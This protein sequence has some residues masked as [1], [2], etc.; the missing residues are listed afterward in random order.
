MRFKLVLFAAVLSGWLSACK[1][2][3]ISSFNKDASFINFKQ[4]NLPDFSF[5]GYMRNEVPIPLVPVKITLTPEEGHDRENIQNAIDELSIQPLVDGFRGA[6]LLKAGTYYID[7]TIFITASGI[8]VRGEGQGENGTVL[9]ATRS[10]ADISPKISGKQQQTLFTLLGAASGYIDLGIESRIVTDFVDVG[11]KVVEVQNNPGFGVGDT[12]SVVKTT[13]DYWINSLNMAQYGWRAKDY[14]IDHIRVISKIDGN[15]IHFDIPLGDHL[16][17]IEGGGKIKRIS[18]PRRIS[19][20]GIENMRMESVYEHDE[21]EQHTWSAIRLVGVENCWVRNITAKYFAY[22]AVSLQAQ[23]DFNTIQDCAMLQPK[24]KNLGDR[25]YAFYIAQGTGNLFQRCYSD[26]GRHDFIT[27][28]RVTGPNVFLDSYAP[29]SLDE[30]GPHHRWATGTLFDNIYAGRIAARNRKDS[31]SG[32][33]WTGAFN[34]FWNCEATKGFRIESPPGTVN[35]LIGGDGSSSVGTSYT[36][37]MGMKVEPRS[38][39]IEQ[40]TTRLGLSKAKGIVTAKQLN[41]SV[42]PDL[43]GW[44]GNQTPLKSTDKNL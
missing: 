17:A 33:G 20:S 4:E 38:L 10:G 39:F 29:T 27:G 1:K 15:Q 26:Q 8:V 5:A 14:Q 24:S 21:D 31:G 16:K 7:N 3:D 22:T 32:H 36:A 34:M 23:S 11:S 25:R 41:S 19:N 37:S 35:W 44:A 42:W 2:A 6:I 18:F 9:I 30:T 28:A 13:N 43:A 40:L 12:I